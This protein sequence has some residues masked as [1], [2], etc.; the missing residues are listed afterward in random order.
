LISLSLKS[1]LESERLIYLWDK[2]ELFDFACLY[3]LFKDELIT[4]A[5]STL[6]LKAD[7]KFNEPLIDLDSLNS[8]EAIDG[9]LKGLLIELI[10]L[11]FLR[12]GLA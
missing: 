3:C 1:F 11:S 7:L 12:N 5:F 4:D 2:T 10:E 6:C 9:C 8:L